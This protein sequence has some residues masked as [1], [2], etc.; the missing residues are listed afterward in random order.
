MQDR[1]RLIAVVSAL[2]TVICLEKTA[3]AAQKKTVICDGI[4]AEIELHTNRS[5]PMALVYDHTAESNAHTCVVDFG[6]VR[7][8]PLRGT[9]WNGERCALSGPYYNRI[10]KT[11][12]MNKWDKAEAPDHPK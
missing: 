8:W 1:L 6:R 9:C 11:Y 7:H 2:V 12:Y 10:G 5:F 4:L 3:W